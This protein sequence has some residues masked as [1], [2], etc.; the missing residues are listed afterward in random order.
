MTVS[1]DKYDNYRAALL[2]AGAPVDQVEAVI[3]DMIVEDA[4]DLGA[5]L[6]QVPRADHSSDRSASSRLNRSRRQ[7]V[8]LPLHRQ[9]RVVRR[10]VRAGRRE[11]MRPP[12]TVHVA[13]CAACG[14]IVKTSTRAEAAVNADC[15]YCPF[16][17]STL[18]AFRYQLAPKVSRN[19]KKSRKAPP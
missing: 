2:G 3:A 17:A 9:M 15:P 13:L 7:M 4:K 5:R 12:T 14:C 16:G 10:P 8:Q 11:L 6:P 1:K 18:E 19:A